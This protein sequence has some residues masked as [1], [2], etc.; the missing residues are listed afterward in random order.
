MSIVD[1]LGKGLNDN[2]VFKAVFNLFRAYRTRPQDLVFEDKGHDASAHLR[3]EKT[4][5]ETGGAEHAA[6]AEAW[7]LIL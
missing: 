5:A 6:P 1:L 7:D 3:G 4:S 2:Q